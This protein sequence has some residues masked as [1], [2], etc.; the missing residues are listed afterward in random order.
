MADPVYDDK[1]DDLDS[2]SPEALN[3]LEQRYSTN[4][5]KNE[6]LAAEYG[7]NPDDLPRK[8]MGRRLRQRSEAKDEEAADA[9]NNRLRDEWRNAKDEDAG[10]FKQRSEGQVGRGYTG[11][12]GIGAPWRKKRKLLAISSI[13]GALLIAGTVS[14]FSFLNVFKLDHLMQNIDAKTFARLNG[15]LEN[16]S[17]KYINAYMTLRLADIGNNPDLDK[18]N[19]PDNLILRSNRVDNNNPLFDW[20]KTMRASKFEQDV[21]EKY[22]FKFTSVAKRQGNKIVFRPGVIKYNDKSVKFDLKTNEIRD[23]ENG[24]INGLN[25]RLREFVELKEFDNDKEGRRAIKRAVN[26][27]TRFYEVF[28]RRMVRKAIQNMTG[29]R[30]WRFFENKR[31]KLDEKTIDIRNKLITKAIPESTKSGKFVYCLFGI[32]NCIYNRDPAA[33]SNRAESSLIGDTDIKKGSEVQRRDGLDVLPSESVDLS[34]ATDTVKKITAN[35][36]TKANAVLG[37]LN[38]ISTLDSLSL[39]NKAIANHQISKGIAVARGVQAMGLYQVFGTARDQVKSGDI[40]AA[41]LNKFMPLVATAASSEAYTKVIE[42]KGDAANITNTQAS[43]SYCDQSHQTLLEKDPARAEK[44]Y[45]FLCPNAQ[46]GG[47]NRAA[48]IELAYKN[49]VGG[50]IQPILAVYEKGRNAPIFGKVIDL[51][52]S[53]LSAVSEAV[54]GAIVKATGLQGPI[55]DLMANITGRL[56]A[57]LGAGPIM[58]GLEPSGV[59]MNWVMQGAAYSSEATSRSLGGSITTGASAKLSRESLAVY[60]RDTAANRSL[61]ERYLST[62]S[63]DS[64]TSRSLVAVSNV[65]S[66]SLASF[67]TSL[68]RTFKSFASTISMPFSGKANAAGQ[69]G[70]RAADF[71]GIQTYDFPATCYDNDPISADPASGTNIIQIVGGIP[72][73]ELTWD[74][75]TDADAW[76]KYVYEK[77]GEDTENADLVAEKIYNCH[78]LDTAVRSG[79]GYVYG[80]KNDNGLDES[81][82]SSSAQP[83]TSDSPSSTAGSQIVGNVG[84]NS[85]SVGCAPGTKDLGIVKTRYTGQY[86]TSSGPLIIRLCQVSSIPGNGDATNGNSLSGGATVNS[87]VSG[88]WQALGQAAQ[89]AN[90]PISSNSSFRLEDSCGGTGDGIS[91]AK[92][93]TSPH[94]TGIAIDFA[95]MSLKGSST[96]SCSGRAREPANPTW[97]WLYK[98]AEKFGIKQYSYESWH[99]DAIPIENRCGTND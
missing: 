88:A 28:K 40:Q 81:G 69:D 94:Q 54:V 23:I 31:N 63:L 21:F 87:R 17:T 83:P 44:E 98:N 90:I 84:D 42:N 50:V 48:D 22:G 24:N 37:P 93:G 26:D 65:D 96:T 68:P 10:N 95:Q 36:L 52:Q 4:R 6:D 14:M 71:A 16:R 66:T 20:Y 11:L 55:E 45:A 27:N 38:I 39:I 5:D 35:I 97:Q 91:C 51:A 49:S 9:L 70:Y 82:S 67:F 64:I 57:F 89:S 46:I 2:L 33:P 30:D 8:G 61:A 3:D 99:W 77:I 1:K 19:D 13:F 80:Y 92:P 18:P 79:L 78:L 85:D 32:S 58:N 41:E 56:V 73:S 34:P 72:P 59:T 43:K 15:N 86:K 12:S 60:Q 25:G 74:L 53:L 76:Y 47:G 7:A 29:V 62:G 75:V